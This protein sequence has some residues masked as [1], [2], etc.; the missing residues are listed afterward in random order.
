MKMYVWLLPILAKALRIFFDG[1][2]DTLHF[3]HD[4][5][6]FFRIRAFFLSL[7]PIFSGAY[8]LP[9]NR[10]LILVISLGTNICLSLFLHAGHIGLLL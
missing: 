6:S 1:P 5:V 3:G 9:H 10:L 4:I 8:V 7:L 2:I